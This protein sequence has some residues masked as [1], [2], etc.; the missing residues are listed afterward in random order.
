MDHQAVM[1]ILSG[2]RR[3][4]AARLLR[5]GLWLASKPYGAA[6]R[7]R[8]WAYR[9]GLLPSQAAAAARPLELD[10]FGHAQEQEEAVELPVISVGNITTGGTGKTPMVAWVASQLRQQGRSPAILTRG[11]KSTGGVSDEAQLLRRLTGVPV[12][13]NADRLQGACD[14]AAGGADVLVMDDGFQHRRLRRNLDIVLID[15]T[16]PFGYGHCLPR[17]LM[18]EGPWALRDAGAIVIT[19][20]DLVSQKSLAALRDKLK[21]RAP[22]ASLH[23]AEHHLTRFVSGDSDVPLAAARGK[24]VFAFCGIG[25][26]GGFFT[27]LEGLGAVIAGTWALEDHAAYTPRLLA[28]IARAAS[29]AEA[30]VLVTTQKDA[31]KIIELPSPLPLW[32][33][34]MEMRIVEGREELVSKLCPST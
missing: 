1:E 17:G 14:A 21:R 27:A 34:V 8:R 26:P 11:Y 15:A 2:R 22:K 10:R 18:R 31:V 5:T 25:N 20:S 29:A 24:R 30:S 28:D 9:W 12:I 7:V 16:N 3:D 6:L 19:R 32:E 23:V 4:L 33:L 13:V